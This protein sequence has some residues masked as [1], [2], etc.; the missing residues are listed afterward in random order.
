MYGESLLY[1]YLTSSES[2]HLC[3]FIEA[4][5]NVGSLIIA[6]SQAGR[7]ILVDR[8]SRRQPLLQG[9]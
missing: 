2:T 3:Q 6:V 7:H 5:N 4:V 9:P 8:M 1:V